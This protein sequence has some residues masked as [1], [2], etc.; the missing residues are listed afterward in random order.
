[1]ANRKIATDSVVKDLFD[2]L[3]RS[4]LQAGPSTQSPVEPANIFFRET[5]SAPVAIV[6]PE[7]VLIQI[8]SWVKEKIFFWSFLFLFLPLLTHF[9]LSYLEKDA[10]LRKTQSF[11]ELKQKELSF[12]NTELAQR[13]EKAWELT[14]RIRKIQAEEKDYAKSLTFL[15]AHLRAGKGYHDFLSELYR[16]KPQGIVFQEVSLRESQLF[17]KG[18]ASQGNLLLEF[19]G[20]LRTLNT[21]KAVKLSVQNPSEPVS[22][23]YA[24]E[25]RS[26]VVA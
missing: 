2:P 18:F 19:S 24:F 20:K 12:W 25:V 15:Q 26:H 7:S 8:L 21:L 10:R 23:F 11:L 4:A 14:N 9:S 6:P 3:K 22:S 5:Q 13:K 17:L 16:N 1:M